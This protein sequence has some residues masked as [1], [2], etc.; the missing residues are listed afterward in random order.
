MNVTFKKHAKEGRYSSFQLDITDIK[1]RK[2]VVGCIYERRNKPEAEK[3]EIRFMVVD[4]ASGG[5]FKWIT[6]MAKFAT[7][8]ACRD[9][10]TPQRMAS[11][12]TRYPL[13]H[14]EP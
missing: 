9:Y 10:L 14:Q 1:H 3:Y 7:E 2:K 6:L 11:I 5:N 8:Q 13:H 4:P 12:N